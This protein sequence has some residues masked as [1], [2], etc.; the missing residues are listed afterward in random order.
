M[1]IVQFF[2]KLLQNAQDY[3]IIVAFIGSR[4]VKR[5][6]RSVLAMGHVAF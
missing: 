6:R 5:Y 4:V 3:D 2:E 1:R